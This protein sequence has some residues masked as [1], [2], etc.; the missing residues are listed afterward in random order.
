MKKITKNVTY[1]FVRSGC[2]FVVYKYLQ[3]VQ[4]KHLGTWYCAYGAC[5]LYLCISLSA[6]LV[7]LFYQ[8][9]HSLALR[10]VLDMRKLPKKE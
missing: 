1:Q 10:A 9:I 3:I 7:Q 2:F 8:I 6:Q 4:K 5:K